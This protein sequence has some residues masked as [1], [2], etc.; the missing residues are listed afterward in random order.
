LES[1]V[2]EIKPGFFEV[3]S[4]RTSEIYM[5]RTGANDTTC[6][7]PDFVHRGVKCKHMLAVELHEGLELKIITGA[8]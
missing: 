6:S 4:Q 2:R 3:P 7:C 1:F 8:D 5:V